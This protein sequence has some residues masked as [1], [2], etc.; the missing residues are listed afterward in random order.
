MTE[1]RMTE[2]ENKLE[3]IILQLNS[4]ESLLNEIAQEPYDTMQAQD[5]AE[6]VRQE[7]Y[8]HLHLYY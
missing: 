6:E 8:Q 2:I 7:L 1:K 4:V 5:Y 3:R